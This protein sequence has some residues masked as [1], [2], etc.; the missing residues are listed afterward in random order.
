MNSKIRLVKLI[1]N[2]HGEAGTEALTLV[3]V[4]TDHPE[5]ITPVGQISIKDGVLTIEVDEQVSVVV[6]KTKTVV[7]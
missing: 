2:S 7:I 5:N 4:T 3:T 6:H 1:P